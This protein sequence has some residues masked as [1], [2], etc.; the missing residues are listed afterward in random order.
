MTKTPA[1]KTIK[2]LYDEKHLLKCVVSNEDWPHRYVFITPTQLEEF[3]AEG[4][5][6]EDLRDE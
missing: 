2:I 4:Y 6:M 1:P 3:L 5:E